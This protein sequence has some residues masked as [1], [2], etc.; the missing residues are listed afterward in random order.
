MKQGQLLFTKDGRVVGNAIIIE[1]TD[2]GRYRIETDFG[3]GG[4]VYTAA[5][6]EARWHHRDRDGFERIVHPRR[7]R[8]ERSAAQAKQNLENDLDDLL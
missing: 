2:N 8:S 1:V 4:F 7:W 6:V 3:N 5:E